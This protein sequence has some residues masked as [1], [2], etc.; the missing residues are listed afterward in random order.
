[1]MTSE[2]FEEV[3]EK[4]ALEGIKAL[5]QLVDDN[6]N[7]E[8]VF[9]TPYRVIKA[10]KEMC[11]KPGDPKVLLS[12]TFKVDD[13][14]SMIAVGPISF[15][16]LCEHHLLPF[17]GQAWVAY[18]PAE[19]EGKVVGL[20]KLPRLVHHFAQRL[21]VQE[22]LTQQ[23]TG[24]LEEHLTPLGSACLIKSSHSCMGLRGVRTPEASMITSSLT[25]V[26]RDEPEVRAEFMALTK[27]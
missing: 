6:P 16:S 4:T 24:S 26:F 23:I 27:Q 8:G 19:G 9:E 10:Y 12:K 15:S 3:L 17:T 20:S 7:R 11:S 2:T 21:Q 25:G 5:I 13:A 18:I 1:M 22:R 14:D